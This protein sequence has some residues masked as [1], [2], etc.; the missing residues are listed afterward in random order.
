MV[1]VLL[2]GDIGEKYIRFPK[3]KEYVNI[4]SICSRRL[5]CYLCAR[6]GNFNSIPKVY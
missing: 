2:H 4:D 6:G 5:I 1:Q 3:R